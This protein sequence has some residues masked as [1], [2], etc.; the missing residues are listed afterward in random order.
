MVKPVLPFFKD[1]PLPSSLVGRVSRG[2]AVVHG[3]SRSKV[4]GPHFQQGG[5]FVVEGLGH[6]SP[7]ATLVAELGHQVDYVNVR[8]DSMLSEYVAL[9]RQDAPN[10]ALNGVLIDGP[11]S[12]L[13]I[14]RCEKSQDSSFR[15]ELPKDMSP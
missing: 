14:R 13:E 12:G 2:A 15:S 11:A 3:L 6:L 8:G 10:K 1:R 5:R 7:L 9:G 4:T